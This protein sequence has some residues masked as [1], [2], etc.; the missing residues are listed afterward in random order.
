MQGGPACLPIPVR[1]AGAQSFILSFH[2]ILA[3]LSLSLSVKLSTWGSVR[4][5]DEK[6]LQRK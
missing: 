6:R 1:S 4:G 3:F 5:P 2:R